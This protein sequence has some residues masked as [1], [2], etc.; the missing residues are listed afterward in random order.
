MKVRVW[1][2][3][4][5]NN[6][7]SYTIVGSFPSAELASEVAEELRELMKAHTIWLEASQ[8]ADRKDSDSP[9]SQFVKK[10]GLRTHDSDY[11]DWPQYSSDNTPRAVAIDTKVIIHH[12]Y[13]V[14]LPREFGEFFYV[15][16]GRVDHELNHAHNPLVAICELWVPWSDRKDVNV[17]DKASA[18]LEELCTPHGTFLEQ[19]SSATR[20]R[21]AWQN[22]DGLHS[23]DLVIGAIFDDLVVGFAEV[24]SLARKYGFKIFVKVQESF[25]RDIDPLAFLRPS[26]P[27]LQRKQCAIVLKEKGNTPA[28]VVRVL[29]YFLK[30]DGAGARE[31]L[32]S[33][34]IEILRDVF[35]EE[36]ER[37][38]SSLAGAGA[39]VSLI[40]KE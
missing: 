21:P 23:P 2:A 3:F 25:D 18:L 36:A 1:N 32:D 7:G 26:S 17:S 39:V 8:P 30:V 28:E 31:I 22:G 33:A 12:E 20:Y 40:N 34:P 11:E 37:I 13:T 10:H 27:E 6:S 16:G 9:L 24:N 14:T 35:E 19:S 15:R 29:E 38:S 4:A 5:S